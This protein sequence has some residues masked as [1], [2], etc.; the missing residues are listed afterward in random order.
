LV[1][2]KGTHRNEAAQEEEKSRHWWLTPVIP[3][4]W[5]AEIGRIKVQGQHKQIV[6]RHP[7]PN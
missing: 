3:A 4:S 1:G 5:E 2:R 7:S 6:W